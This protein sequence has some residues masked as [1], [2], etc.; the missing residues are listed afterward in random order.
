MNDNLPGEL[1]SVLVFEY[2]RSAARNNIIGVWLAMTASFNYNNTR[3]IVQF[4]VVV[5][6]QGPATE[7]GFLKIEGG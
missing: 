2:H 6:A 7:V 4:I 3:R 5:N 1:I